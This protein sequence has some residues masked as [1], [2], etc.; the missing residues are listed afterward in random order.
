MRE[1]RL[2]LWRVA[3]ARSDTSRYASCTLRRCPEASR[4]CQE[5]RNA[6]ARYEGL[7]MPT[8]PASPDGPRLAI[9]VRPTKG[10]A[11]HRD[12]MDTLLPAHIDDRLRI[13]FALPRRNPH[14]SSSG[15]SWA[16]RPA[17]PGASVQHGRTA[18]A[19]Q[20]PPSWASSST[21]HSPGRRE[22]ARRAPALGPW[23]ALASA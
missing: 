23:P 15:S 16:T 1:A 21:W 20:I 9:S 13:S 18:F 11:T 4:R 22:Q 5:L 8:P 17:P 2:S 7:P 12:S 3:F 10:L 19:R 14:E 6:F